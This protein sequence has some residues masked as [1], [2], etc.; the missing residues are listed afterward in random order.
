M[1]SL[2]RQLPTSR[3]SFHLHVNSNFGGHMFSILSCPEMIPSRKV[4]TAIVS[5]TCTE[6][7]QLRRRQRGMSLSKANTVSVI[8]LEREAS[9]V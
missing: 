2:E 9:W 6:E 4:A 3:N 7:L 5:E 1:K 8:G